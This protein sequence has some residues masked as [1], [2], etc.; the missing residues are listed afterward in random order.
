MSNRNLLGQFEPILCPHKI[1]GKI[2]CKECQKKMDKERC[3]RYRQKPTSILHKNEW[4]QKYNK[5]PEVKQ[6]KKEHKNKPESIQQRKEYRQRPE[7]KLHHQIHEFNRTHPDT[8]FTLEGYNN[9]LKLQNYCCAI[10]CNSQIKSSWHIDH[11]GNLVRGLLCIN[12][13]AQ[14]VCGYELMPKELQ[15]WQ[16]LNDYINC[17]LPFQRDYQTWLISWIEENKK[18][19]KA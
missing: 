19:F 2:K 14:L 5:K 11:K 7:V 16:Y 18:L 17:N 6:Y 8:I 13:N 4:N 3:A 12:C 1:L 9:L 10:C 15:T